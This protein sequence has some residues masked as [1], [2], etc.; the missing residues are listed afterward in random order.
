MRFKW[1]F[2]TEPHQRH[3][4]C[5]FHYCSMK[6]C[7]LSSSNIGQF[8]QP[9]PSILTSIPPR[10]CIPLILHRLTHQWTACWGTCWIGRGGRHTAALRVWWVI[11]CGTLLPKGA[12]SAHLCMLNQCKSVQLG[13]LCPSWWSAFLYCSALICQGYDVVSDTIFTIKKWDIS[14][15]KLLCPVFLL[16]IVVLGRSNADLIMPFKNA[17]FIPN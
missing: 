14:H 15:S 3:R 7:I 13:N 4:L 10:L 5:I 9:Q 17:R 12:C 6:L 8:S 2:I 16:P 11:D 1:C